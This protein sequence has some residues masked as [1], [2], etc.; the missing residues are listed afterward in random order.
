MSGPDLQQWLS[1][2]RRLEGCRVV[3]RVEAHLQLAEPIP[4]SGEHRMRIGLQVRLEP[5]LIKLW[6]AERAEACRQALERS[7]EPELSNDYVDDVAEVGFSCEFES[8]LGL[9]PHVAKRISGCEKNRNQTIARID[10]VLE[11]SSFLRRLEGASQQFETT[12]QVP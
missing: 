6:I 8:A 10:C 5:A 9:A 7:D 2:R 3:A 12:A 1:F 4:T 11:V